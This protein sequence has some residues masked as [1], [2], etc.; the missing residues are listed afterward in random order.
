MGKKILIIKIG[1]IGDIIMALPTLVS[2]K[3]EFPDSHITWIC[4]KSVA[5][6]LQHVPAINKLIIVDEKKIFSKKIFGLVKEFFS[7]YKKNFLKKYDIILNFHV[8]SRYKLFQQFCLSSR[9]A[10]FERN[11][12]RPIPLPGRSR[13]FEHIRLF[14]GDDKEE[15]NFL[16]FPDFS[17]EPSQERKDSFDVFTD[18]IVITPGGANNILREDTLRRWPINNYREL[19]I[20]LIAKKRK[21]V[22]VGAK[23]DSWIIP[24]FEDLDVKM[25]VGELDL[26]ELIYCISKSKA[27]ITHDSGPYHLGVFA[28]KPQV[29]VL[30]GPTSSEEFSYGKMFDNRVKRLWKGNE[31]FCSP[32]YYGKHYSKGCKRNI[33][34]EFLSVDYVLDELND[35]FDV[36]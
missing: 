4:G 31:L 5:P 8:D 10:K 26:T 35:I 36:Q 29:I 23:S 20:N 15:Q 24:Y 13:V 17:F 2:I 11:T 9:K 19:A 34:M 16:S 33:C 18:S 25:V 12:E 3:S 21:V 28:K 27:I 14:Y 7:L 1:A 32:C 22:I 30:F 6:I